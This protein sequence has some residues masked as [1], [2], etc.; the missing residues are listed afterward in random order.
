MLCRRNCVVLFIVSALVAMVLAYSY[1]SQQELFALLWNY[2]YVVPRILYALRQY[3]NSDIS[4]KTLTI[5]NVFYAILQENMLDIINVFRFKDELSMLSW[6]DKTLYLKVSDV[7]KE[8]GSDYYCFKPESDDIYGV[9]QWMFFVNVILLLI[10]IGVDLFGMRFA[11]IM[12]LFIIEAQFLTFLNHFKTL[13]N[14]VMKPATAVKCF[15]QGYDVK[16]DLHNLYALFIW[17]VIGLS[18]LIVLWF[19][20]NY[21]NVRTIVVTVKETV[22]ENVTKYLRAQPRVDYSE[23]RRRTKRSKT[24]RR[25]KTPRPKRT[26]QGKR[27]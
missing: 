22:R 10:T 1:V 3:M 24:R 5:A 25:S 26:S 19:G 6:F 15:K 20:T 16:D 9:Y 4:T 14:D 8:S 11:H 18:T 17:V 7:T 21:H 12:P 23:T 27:K 13:L 2:W